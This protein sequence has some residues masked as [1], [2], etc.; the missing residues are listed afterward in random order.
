ML[1]F[2]NTSRQTNTSSRVH[3]FINDPTVKQ[4]FTEATE[5]FRD[6]ARLKR[7]DTTAAWKWIRLTA[8]VRSFTGF[9]LLELNWC[10]F[11]LWPGASH[12]HTSTRAQ[13]A[14]NGLNRVH[15]LRRG[16]APQTS[17]AGSRC[18]S[19]SLVSSISS[20]SCS[21]HEQI[22]PQ[23]RDTSQFLDCDPFLFCHLWYKS[24]KTRFG[25]Q[26]RQ[27]NQRNCKRYFGDRLTVEY[28]LLF[29]HM[30]MEDVFNRVKLKLKCMFIG[31]LGYHYLIL[32]SDIGTNPGENICF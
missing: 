27:T 9:V 6:G 11:D 3:I 4:H 17:E 21:G 13:S 2:P 15:R 23:T 1:T 29:Y 32:V 24:V 30:K 10:E 5:R 12:V 26:R 8:A 18:S 31:G 28:F 19:V 22:L 25:A 14:E 7:G 20:L 16:S